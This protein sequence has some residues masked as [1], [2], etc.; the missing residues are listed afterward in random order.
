M[1][2]DSKVQFWN[3]HWNISQWPS[4]LKR[5][6]ISIHVKSE[7]DFWSRMHA[8]RTMLL[9][10][11]SSAVLCEISHVWAKS[12]NLQSPGISKLSPGVAWRRAWSSPPGW[13]QRGHGR[14]ATVDPTSTGK[15]SVYEKKT[16]GQSQL[17]FWIFWKGLKKKIQTGSQTCKTSAFTLKHT[18]NTCSFP[19]PTF[20]HLSVPHPVLPVMLNCTRGQ[21]KRV[22]V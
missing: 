2:G 8:I 10:M 5:L 18:E 6:N 3:L 12:H 11:F 22:Y 19:T 17:V 7:K 13:K 14:T 20:S 15:T 16:E 9:S 21:G 4:H 1:A